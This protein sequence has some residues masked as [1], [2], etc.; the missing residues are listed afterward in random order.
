[1]LTLYF[2]ALRRLSR[3]VLL[4]LAAAAL[5]GLAFDGGV[6]T[7]LFNL[8]LLRVG[9]GP[10]FI[11]QANSAGLLAF[12]VA[13]LP[14]GP[15][16]TRFG[17]RR[18]MVLGLAL[19]GLCGLLGPSVNLFIPE[20]WVGATIVTLWIVM[21]TGMAFFFV[22]A[23]PFVMEI[24]NDEERSQAF[25]LQT[26]L[27]SLFA[28]TGALL[29]GFLPRLFA[30]WLGVDLTDPAPYRFPLILSASVLF[31]PI[32]IILRIRSGTSVST[33]AQALGDPSPSSI[34][35]PQPD[36]VIADSAPRR[37]FGQW[38]S[39]VMITVLLLSTVRFF[40][41]GGIATAFTFFNVYMDTQLMVAPE[42]IGIIAALAR[43]G[44]VFLALFT[45]VVIAKWGAPS[46]V[47]VASTVSTL[48]LL[49]LALVPHPIAAGMGYIGV[50]AFASMRY[51]A[52][53]FFC[54]TLVPPSWRSTVAGMGEFFG[55]LSFALM[56]FVG[57]YMIAWT[58]FPVLFLSGMMLT[59][60]GTALFFFWYILPTRAKPLP[61]PLPSNPAA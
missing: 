37:L 4:Y 51:P 38:A 23:V 12:A 57:G 49:P 3:N 53:M 56:A 11:G 58:G 21:Y 44:G 46:A 39:P 54:M 25:S 41:V 10:E 16:G 43:L 29:G 7:V 61:E 28:F 59:L 50:T 40:Q 18:V 34:A 6:F 47:L 55:G 45:P 32:W 60:I 1:M 26:A 48:S 52:F 42:Q 36:P 5:I 15:L 19:M 31:V 2:G 22:N 17:V 13:S 8:Y 24:A 27:I 14:S 30:G 20:P 9:F 35:T 33:S